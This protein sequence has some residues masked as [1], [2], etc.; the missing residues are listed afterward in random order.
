MTAVAQL[1]ALPIV[2]AL[3]WTLLHFCWQG[4]IV[5][6]LL[7][8]VLNLLP[9]SASKLRY[10]AGCAA[11]ASL[12]ALPLITFAVLLADQQ[13]APRQL[14]IAVSA[15]NPGIAPNSS[16]A[17]SAEPWSVR[18]ETALNNS[19]PAV[20]GF[21]LAGVLIFLCRL[22]L[23]LVATRRWKSTGAEPAAAEHQ[24]I[25]QALRIRLG[26]K[27]VVNLLNSARVHSPTVIG[28]MRPAI[29]LPLGCMTGLSQ[30]QIEAIFAHELAHIR[31][32]D[33]LVNLLQSVMETLLFYHP[34]VWWVSTQVRRE[35][36]HC[37]DDL[38]V[39]VTGDRLS[40]ATALSY[41]EERRGGAAPAGALAAT[42]GILKMR[43]ARLLGLSAVPVFPRTAAIILFALA[44][45]AA[46]LIA[47][48]AAR[49][50]SAASQHD[51]PP[52]NVALDELAGPYKQ[53]LNQEVRWI[54]MP[55]EREAFLRLTNN[56][57]RDNF[58]EQFWQR[59]NPNPGSLKNAFRQEHN[60]RI[61]Y[62]NTHFAAG[63]P[64]WET[65]RGHVYIVFGPPDTIDSHPG[66]NSGSTKPFEI[67]RY[68][69]IQVQEP[70]VNNPGGAGYTAQSAVKKD[71]DFHFVDDCNCGHYILQSA[72]PTAA[73][74]NVPPHAAGD[75]RQGVQVLSDT[76]GVDFSAWLS[77]WWQATHNNFNSLMPTDRRNA[78]TATIRFKVLPNGRI[79]DG[80]MVLEG[81]SNNV[82]FDRSAW[83]AVTGSSYP[84]LPSGFNGSYLE[85]R[86]VFSNPAPAEDSSHVSGDAP[87]HGTQQAAD[88]SVQVRSLTIVSDDLPKSDQL[89]IVQKY[90]GRAYP[91][92]E[93]KERIRQNVRDLGYAKARVEFL[94]PS[95]TPSGRPP[96]SMDISVRVSAGAQYRL[97][98]F[99]INGAQAFSQDEIIRQFPIH[100]GALF[101]ATAIGKGL[102]SLKDLYGAKGYVNFGVIPRM[103][104]DDVRQTVTLVLDINE[105]KRQPQR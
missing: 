68:R 6:V 20:V 29:L 31:R 57:E 3:G 77:A 104:F 79:M 12:I 30:I 91:L 98:G 49:A 37:C 94:Q 7:A 25:L 47:H 90:Q 61:A 85:L 80:S 22:N 10:A 67:W 64:G 96:Q 75:A 72:W 15:G 5:A 39:A 105:G 17:Q 66:G 27:R 70:A 69:S 35:R 60:R 103:Q 65:D 88:V 18:C 97:S 13:P 78:G 42:G 95:A 86:A 48:G 23:G 89:Q 38:A 11:L 53:W 51:S 46:G 76:E 1:S 71:F 40:Y 84:P 63:E 28:W 101:N 44:G 82:A 50:Q 54:I 2:H 19:M 73:A 93:L 81:R 83:S 9:L 21:W 58:I 26:I 102:D 36:E 52:N 16:V 56:H 62:S 8:C 45:T 92:E 74:L 41:L 24:D 34:A 55:E 33:Y 87:Q 99:S 59:R 43:I 100:P 14:I 4:T 32:H